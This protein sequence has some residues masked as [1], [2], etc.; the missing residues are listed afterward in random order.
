MK[1]FNLTFLSL[2]FTFVSVYG[3]CYLGELTFGEDAKYFV[4][5]PALLIGMNTRK[6]M[7]KILGY[8]MEQAMKEGSN[9]KG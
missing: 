2:G 4:I 5:L 8:T 1:A 3:I 6:I 7:E 9:G